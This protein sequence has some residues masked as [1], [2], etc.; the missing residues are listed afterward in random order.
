MVLMGEVKMQTQFLSEN[1]K[2]INQF[3]GIGVGGV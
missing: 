1:L 2:G 3:G